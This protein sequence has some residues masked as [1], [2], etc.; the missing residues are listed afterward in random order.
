MVQSVGTEL[1]GALDPSR[2]QG[3]IPSAAFLTLYR[4]NRHQLLASDAGTIDAA[5]AHPREVSTRSG[6]VRD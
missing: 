2:T 3:L 6:T 1:G 5:S 4:I